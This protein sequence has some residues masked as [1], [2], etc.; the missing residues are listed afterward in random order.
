MGFAF[1]TMA[2]LLIPQ[3]SAYSQNSSPSGPEFVGSPDGVTSYDTKPGIY[4]NLPVAWFAPEVYTKTVSGSIEYWVRDTAK[5]Y[6]DPRPRYYFIDGCGIGTTLDYGPILRGGIYMVR[7]SRFTGEQWQEN[8]GKET[9]IVWISVPGPLMESGA[10]PVPAKF[11]P[12][13]NWQEEHMRLLPPYAPL[14]N[15]ISVSYV[16]NIGQTDAD[17]FRFG[18]T[19]TPTSEDLTKRAITTSV[20]LPT[21]WRKDLPTDVTEGERNLNNIGEAGLRLLTDKQLDDVANMPPAGGLWFSDL[22]RS[23]SDKY[24]WSIPIEA[25]SLPN[26]YKLYEKLRAKSESRL[27]G[28]YY[29]V[30]FQAKGFHGADDGLPRPLDKNFVPSIENPELRVAGCYRKFQHE[31]RTKSMREVMNIFTADAYPDSWLPS[32]VADQQLTPALYHIYSLLF[33]LIQSRRV[34]PSDQKVVTFAWTQTDS[35]GPVTRLYFQLPNGRAS[36]QLRTVTPA[37]WA[38][39]VHMLSMIGGDGI[40]W[41]TEGIV[42]GTNITRLGDGDGDPRWDPSV[43]DAP[44]P[45]VKNYV[46]SYPRHPFY[47]YTWAKLGEYQLK[48]VEQSL[49]RWEFAPYQ[50][51]GRTITPVTKYSDQGANKANTV[52]NLADKRQP[53]V[54]VTGAAGSQALFAVH[55]FGDWRN[56]YKLTVHYNGKQHHITVSGKWPTL[57]KLPPQRM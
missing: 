29:R 23:N 43:K 38:Q 16:R 9:H 50:L 26:Y 8:N 15:K 55:P 33:D 36:Y 52:L 3:G 47:N 46:N 12:T 35:E 6:N 18:A 45:F 28:D 5:G 53:I 24:Y 22:E 30:L 39:S 32:R 17:L 51:E 25:A 44:S 54:M 7:C 49:D 40:K 42:N 57:V 27:V 41:W 11:Q 31:G 56:R 13:S 4:A 10:V 1:F 2:S 14:V 21:S 37:W 20:E 48:P 19:H 34:L